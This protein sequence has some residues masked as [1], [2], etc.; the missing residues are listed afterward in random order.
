MK[1]LFATLALGLSV[2]TAAL[3]EPFTMGSPQ[4]PAAVQSRPMTGSSSPAADL[5][6]FTERDTGYR[7]DG[8]TTSPMH[9]P[10]KMTGAATPASRAPG[11]AGSDAWNS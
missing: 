7:R 3:A 8:S 1:T 9:H 11:W 4:H 5:S 2:S 10:D 6:G